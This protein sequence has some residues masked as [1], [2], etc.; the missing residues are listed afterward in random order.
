[1]TGKRTF[2]LGDKIDQTGP[3]SLTRLSSDLRPFAGELQ[4]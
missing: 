4:R 3:L 2:S 1:M